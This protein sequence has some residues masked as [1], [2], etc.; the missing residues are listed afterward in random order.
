MP[1]ITDRISEAA[2]AQVE[3]MQDGRT[4]SFEVGISQTDEHAHWLMRIFDNENVEQ[5]M[6]W[7]KREN[8]H[9]ANI[10]IRPWGEHN[11][12]LVDDVSEASIEKMKA[13]GFDPAVVLETSPK[14]K[15]EPGPNFQAWLNHGQVVPNNVSTAL[16]QRLAQDFGGDTKA[17]DWR[18]YGRLAGFSNRKPEHQREDGRFP[19]V[20]L[21]EANGKPYERAE[22]FVWKVKHDI[23]R[24]QHQ[25]KLRRM[26]Y[27]LR[28]EKFERPGIQ[29][30]I[31]D[32][33]KDL[34]YGGDMHRADFAFA[35]YAGS[36]GLSDDAIAAA[37]ASRDLAK[38]GREPQQDAYIRRTIEKARGMER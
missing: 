20:K 36:R 30:T 5:S 13:A 29:K 8:A 33:R 17:S 31:E 37:I 4:K 16:A 19:F 9:G 3:A 38:K 22:G 26:L 34:R 27:D 25:A 6:G 1:T 14:H 12:S 24:T 32:F 2:L 15:T 28:Q 7:L 10:Y 21:I 35:V 23:E 18:H 11:L